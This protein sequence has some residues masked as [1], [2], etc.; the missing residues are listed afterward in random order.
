AASETR[1]G[2]VRSTLPASRSRSWTL[3]TLTATA[4]LLRGP[5]STFRGGTRSA[6]RFLTVS[7]SGSRTWASFAEATVSTSPCDEGASQVTI[8]SSGARRFNSAKPSSAS[9]RR[10]PS[11]TQKNDLPSSAQH[12]QGRTA[13]A[14]TRASATV[15]GGAFFTGVGGGWG[16]AGGWG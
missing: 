3:A 9:R 1:A 2:K 14:L 12:R 6:M 13:L 15:A 5:A 11:S 8:P 4:R 10:T 7:V 16:G